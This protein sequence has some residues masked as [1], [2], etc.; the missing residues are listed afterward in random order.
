M[1]NVREND[2]NKM[3]AQSARGRGRGRSTHTRIAHAFFSFSS[4]YFWINYVCSVTRAPQPKEDALH[5]QYTSICALYV[6]SFSFLFLLILFCFGVLILY[7]KNKYM[8]A[9]ALEWVQRKVQV[10]SGFAAVIPLIVHTQVVCCVSAP[11]DLGDARRLRPP[12]HIRSEKYA[13]YVYEVGMGG[14]G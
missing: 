7:R 12:F 10:C 6:S 14:Y 5:I 2:E 3:C 9:A 13:F 1:K 4:H 11:V 8:Y